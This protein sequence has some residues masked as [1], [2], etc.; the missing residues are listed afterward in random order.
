MVAGVAVPVDGVRVSQETLE[1]EVHATD[2]MVEV[3]AMDC[4]VAAPPGEA[5]KARVAGDAT[6]AFV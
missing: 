6:R 2:A 5:L 4:A 1:D 3:S